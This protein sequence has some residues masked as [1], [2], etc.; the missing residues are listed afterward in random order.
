MRRALAGALV[1]FAALPGAA[2]AQEWERYDDTEQQWC[3]AGEQR[4][5]TDRAAALL[6]YPEEVR[7]ALTKPDPVTRMRLYFESHGCYRRLSETERATFCDA[8]LAAMPDKGEAWPFWD[9]G[10]RLWKAER[11][12]DAGTPKD[13]VALA[14]TVQKHAAKEKDG[15]TE[16]RARWL[17]A[18]AAADAGDTVKAK[19]ES[20]KAW[21]LAAAAG[22]PFLEV[23][24]RV[25]RARL[26]GSAKPAKTELQAAAARI[27]TLVH[28]GD[29]A[30]LL[31]PAVEV[32]KALNLADL[33]DTLEQARQQAAAEGPPTTAT[34]KGSVSTGP[35]LSDVV[36]E[37]KPTDVV[38]EI[39]RDG[40]ELRFDAPR[41][42]RINDMSVTEGFAL[43]MRQGVLWSTDGP[44]VELLGLRM[45]NSTEIGQQK[46]SV[47]P[48][49]VREFVL[50]PGDRV[51]V[52]AS[53]RAIFRRGR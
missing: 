10:L 20:D 12:C 31:A 18:R 4:A 27:A 5:D 25:L 14:E 36:K 13:A 9:D 7:T 11:L 33:A 41:I 32:A 24:L 3:A 43:G 53:G 6:A 21:K 15:H 49:F 29:R 8:L 45:G 40:D 42:G 17:L 28:A 37:A 16:A 38:L 44:R 2:R 50:A 19:Q 35:S 51:L 39:A 52:Q 22:E 34:V 23:R 47:V 48:P 30:E 26:A 46:R 1:A